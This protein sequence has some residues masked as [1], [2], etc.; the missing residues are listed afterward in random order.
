MTKITFLFC[1]WLT[2]ASTVAV[3]NEP[4]ENAPSPALMTSADRDYAAF[5]ELLSAK[6]P[7]AEEGVSP[8]MQMQ[9]RFRWADETRKKLTAAA[10]DFHEK[11]PADARRWDLLMLVFNT[12]PLFIKSFGPD[13]VAKGPAAIVAD[14][15]A[16]AVWEARMEELK[17]S[18]IAADDAPLM[19]REMIEW[20]FFGRDFRGTTTAFRAGK[21]VNWEAFRPR[22]DAYV[23]KYGEAEAMLKV[24]AND[25]LGALER[26][27][28]GRSAAEW[29]HLKATSPS[30]VLREHAVTKLAELAK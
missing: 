18:L 30:A 26:V 13:L 17:R 29:E 12:P 5:E 1:A 2:L 8:E 16:Q 24:R 7:G 3:A 22:F 11:H 9:A 27:V 28:P 15:A 21:P 10:I 19:A 14:E 23:V 4:L 25:Y 6:V 20:S